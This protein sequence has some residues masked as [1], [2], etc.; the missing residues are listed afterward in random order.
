MNFYDVAK[1]VCG[2]PLRTVWRLRAVGTELVPRTGPLIVAS[3][4][5]SFFDPPALG[6]ALPRPL[7]YMAKQ[8]LFEIPLFGPL[9]RATNAYPVD[10][11]RG[12]VG[13]IRRT[14]EM[15]RAGNAVAIFPE[16]GRNK[17]G[18][19][20]ARPGVA[21]LAALSRAPILPAYI[22]GTSGV[23][24]LHAITVIF[25]E[26]FVPRPRGLA[27]LVDVAPP[28]AGAFEKTNASDRKASREDLAKWTDEIMHRIFALREQLRAN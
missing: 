10:R 15:L 27:P 17:N 18:Q 24:R 25:G 8:E 20:K 13:A 16:G 14:V 21:L 28:S 23:R 9:I 7:H 19:A 4:H 26:P 11:S 12:D 3:N 2:V 1:I 6:V 5:I 22:E